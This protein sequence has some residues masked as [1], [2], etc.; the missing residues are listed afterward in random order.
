MINYSEPHITPADIK[1]MND[2]VKRGQFDPARI[3]DSF[4]DSLA[5]RLGL[6][7]DWVMLTNSASSALE[8]LYLHYRPERVKAPVLT[9][10]ASYTFAPVEKRL[11]C[12]VDD[13][14]ILL[15][16]GS[17]GSGQG[18]M[19][20]L[21]EL[22]G[23]R[24]TRDE[25]LAHRLGADYLILDSAQNILSPEIKEL[26]N[27]GLV[28]AVVNSF[29]PI[30][31]LTTGRGGAVFCKDG[32]KLHM[33]MHHGV[34]DGQPLHALGRNA[35]M[36]EPAAA[37]GL[38]QLVRFD[39]MQDHRQNLLMEYNEMLGVR[40]MT[41]VGDYSGHLA[42]MECNDVDHKNMVIQ[43]LFE[44]GF[45]TTTHYQLPQYVDP[46][47]CP[48]AAELSAL[49]LTLPCHMGVKVK[50]VREIAKIVVEV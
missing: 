11:L 8:L 15:S 22:W 44:K 36:T 34:V 16:S 29:G 10:P 33:L 39:K 37:L 19:V 26:L 30:K 1:A 13:N 4:R 50:D 17:I 24:L 31:Q 38:S 25:I 43:K 12:D 46:S 23:R 14:G 45:K 49:V 48:N 18:T 9:W 3:E 2:P 41:K 28:D 6:P 47:G 27:T 32:W 40:M 35:C 5:A 7:R 20:V 42:V 21:V